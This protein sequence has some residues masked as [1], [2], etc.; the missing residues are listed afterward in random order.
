MLTTLILRIMKKWILSVALLI[1]ASGMQAQEIFNTLLNKASQVVNENDANDYNTKINY[2]YF[3]ALN[4]MKTK[5]KPQDVAQYKVLDEQAL[6]MQTYVTEFIGWISRTKDADLRRK[7]IELFVKTSISHPFFDDKDSE[8]TGSFIDDT[9]YITPF[10][11]DTDW[12]KAKSIVDKE[13]PKL[14]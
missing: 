14:N 9:N 13:L 12:V 6:A 10:S 3:T 1:S 2:F 8:T 11:L 5:V 7:G 4:Y